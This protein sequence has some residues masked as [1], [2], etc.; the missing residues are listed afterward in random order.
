MK[1]M[2]SLNG[3][4]VRLLDVIGEITGRQLI[5]APV[6]SNTLAT[7]PFAGTRL[8]GAITT[9]FVGLDLAFHQSH[10]P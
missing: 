6:I 4:V 8:V 9:F 2:K 5:L 1:R 7:D 10:R 3:P